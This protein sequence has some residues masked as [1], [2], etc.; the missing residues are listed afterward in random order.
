MNNIM[1]FRLS[2]SGIRNLS[3]YLF[4]LPFLVGFFWLTV[5]P[6]GMSFYLSFTRYDLL[7]TPEWV[8]FSNYVRMFTND[9]KFMQA[10]KVT[11]FYA[12]KPFRSD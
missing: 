2:K 7:G 5:F 12:F 3:G 4:I 8:G 1:K 10:L 6:I 11:F 9:D